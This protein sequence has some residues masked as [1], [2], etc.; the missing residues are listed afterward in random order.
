MLLPLVRIVNN[1]YNDARYLGW[2]LAMLVAPRH[3]ACWIGDLELLDSKSVR[4]GTLPI[5]T[6][7]SIWGAA[8]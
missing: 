4:F 3:V 6:L 1:N 5:A 7:W 2:V 8:R